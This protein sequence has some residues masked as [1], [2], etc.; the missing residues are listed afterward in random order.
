MSN[1]CG[2]GEFFFQT[3]SA[4][5]TSP[6]GETQ[7]NTVYIARFSFIDP[8]FQEGLLVTVSPDSGGG[9]R[10]AWVGL[11]DTA[12]GVHVS[13]SQSSGADG[14]FADTDLGVLSHGQPHTIEWRIHL[15]PGTANDQVRILIDGRDVGQCFTTWETYYRTAQEQSGP[16]NNAEPPT[17]NSLQFRT[18][19]Q[20]PA[21]LAQSGGYLFDNVSVTTG[22]GPV[23]PGCDV[24]IDK[25]ADAGAVN[26]GGLM[27]Y[28]ITAQNHGSAVA[29]NV[30]VCDHI[31]R[32]TT[33]VRADHALRR[34]GDERCL[35]ISRLQPDQRVSVHLTLR[36]DASAPPGRLTNIADVTP[37]VP[38]VRPPPAVASDLPR[39][40]A[41]PGA[42]VAAVRIRRA[43]AVVKVLA[44]R[45]RPNFTG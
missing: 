45:A 28:R 11:Q 1:L 32:H 27:G 34:V 35:V 29:R 42:R 15:V 12:N 16:P 43:R 38:G 7:P 25:Q 14:A 9:S 31:P 20:G 8:A 17:I 39:P 21:G 33:F 4:P 3:Y 19:V 10:M 26:A 2:N 24:T 40:L 44:R 5:V 36:V 18:S 37:G 6:A 41:R 22:T 13:T 23:S 30:Q